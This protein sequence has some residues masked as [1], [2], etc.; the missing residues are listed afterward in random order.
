LE[1]PILAHNTRFKFGRIALLLAAGLMA[2]MHG[3]LIFFLDDPVLFTGF[4]VFNLY[5]LVV[6]FIPFRR[7][8]K[9]AWAATWLLPVGLA[10]PAALDPDIAI[11]YF[12][13][14]AVC[15]L[16]LILT[17]QDFFSKK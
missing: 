6:I 7:S 12:A 8:E 3:G 10:V 5:A 2:L 9:W 11:L 13:V 15:V 14:A 4:A 16:G 1:T 17:M